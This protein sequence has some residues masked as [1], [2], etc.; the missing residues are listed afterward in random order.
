MEV[1]THWPFSNYFCWKKASACSDCMVG[2]GD[3]FAVDVLVGKDPVS[4]QTVSPLKDVM[5]RASHHKP[6]R[7]ELA[8]HSLSFAANNT[9]PVNSYTD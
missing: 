6:C 7:K 4:R 3:D 5:A 2:D 9:Q 8:E 1:E